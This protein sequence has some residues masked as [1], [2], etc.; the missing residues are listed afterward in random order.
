MTSARTED[1]PGRS[2]GLWREALILTGLILVAAVGSWLVRPD[3]LPLMADAAVYELDLPAPLISFD[4]ARQAYDDGSHVFIDTRTDATLASAV[5][6]AFIVRAETFGPDL[7]AAMDFIY[8]EDPLILYGEDSPL[9]VG[10]VAA[11]FLR[12]GYEQVWIL[13]GGLAY[14]RSRGGPIEQE[15]TDE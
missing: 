11:R 13:E 6:G 5:P 7:E 12:R 14:W 3:R 9:P 8:P 10:D 2:A 1:R 4:E 15:L